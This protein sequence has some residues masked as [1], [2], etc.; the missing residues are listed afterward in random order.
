M[1][2]SKGYITTAFKVTEKKTG[3]HYDCWLQDYEYDDGKHSTRFNI[4]I[5]GWHEWSFCFYLNE[6]EFNEEFVID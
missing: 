2:I 3:N 1:K 6:Q 5:N 4:G